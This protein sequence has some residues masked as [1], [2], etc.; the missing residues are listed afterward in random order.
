MTLIKASI[1]AIIISIIIATIGISIFKGLSL[2]I[3]GI[4]LISLITGSLLMIIVAIQT[5]ASELSSK[6]KQ[7]K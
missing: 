5:I 4:I 7:S 1:F 2:L 3:G 6:V